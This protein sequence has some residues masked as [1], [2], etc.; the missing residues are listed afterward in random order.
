MP[1]ENISC[2]P[3]QLLTFLQTK[4]LGLPCSEFQNTCSTVAPTHPKRFELSHNAYNPQ[5]PVKKD[6]IKIIGHAEGVNG[7]APG[8]KHTLTRPGTWP[9]Q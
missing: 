9:E 1:R 6:K 2:C 3:L 8:Y 7:V 4:P 5:V